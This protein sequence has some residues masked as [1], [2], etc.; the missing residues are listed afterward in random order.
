MNN[1][2][3]QV[4]SS[5]PLS[6]GGKVALALA[7]GWGRGSP[8]YM[9]A[10]LTAIL[11]K[12]GFKTYPFDIN[13]EM[14]HLSKEKDKL[15]WNWEES[16]F[17]QK[18]E[19]LDKYIRDN[20]ELIDSVIERVLSYGIEAVGFSIYSSTKLMSLELAKRIK[21]K[22]KSISVIFG[23]IECQRK[24]D[25]KS[26]LM[27]D[28]VDIL[29]FDEADEVFTELLQLLFNKNDL[30]ICKGIAYKKNGLIIDSGRR[31][32]LSNLDFLPF[33]DF[34]DFDFS[35]YENNNPSVLQI[36]TSRGCSEHCAY[37]STRD[38]SVKFRTMSGSRIF[39][40]I[41]HQAR[42]FKARAKDNKNI[43][44]FLLDLLVNADLKAL[45]EWT[46]KL[47][48]ER[49][50]D[51]YLA[52]IIWHGQIILRKGMSQQLL[53]NIRESG[54][55][56]LNY[57]VESGSSNVLKKMKKR[58]S[59]EE[60]EI[61][62]KEIYDSNIPSRGNFMFG[63]P[64]ETEDDFQ[65]T[66]NFISRTGRYMKEIY[67]SRTFC[68]L[69]RFSYL[70]EHRDEFGITVP[71]EGG[72]NLFWESQDG[73]N[74]YLVRLKRY[75][76]FCKL[77][78]SLPH[79]PLLTG[80]K[81]LKRDNYFNLGEYYRFI[82]DYHKAIENYEK[83]LNSGGSGTSVFN[84]INLC[85]QNLDTKTDNLN[86]E[87]QYSRAKNSSR[88]K[89]ISLNNKEFEEKKIQLKSTPPHIY[90]QIDGPCN[91]NCIFCSRPD[92]YDYFKFDIFHKEL[93]GK[94]YPL[95][96]NAE[97][98]YLTGAGEFLLLEEA[99][100][101]L[102]YFNEEFPDVD[103]MFATNGSIVTPEITREITKSNYQIHVSLHASNAQLHK[104][105][106]YSDNF[107]K[108]IENVKF[109]QD[110]YR[111]YN[112][113]RVYLMFLVTIENIEDL[114]DF[115]ILA[116]KL[117]V[118][119]VYCDFVSIYKIEQKY[120]SVFF[121][122]ESANSIF[123]RSMEL[124][125]QLNITLNLPWKFNQD[126][127]PEVKCTQPWTQVM[128]NSKGDVLPCCLFGDFGENLFNKNFV[129]I[130]NG[131]KYR[132]LRESL[133]GNKDVFCKSCLRKKPSSINEFSAHIISRGLSEDHFEQLLQL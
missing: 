129:E 76:I 48:K 28:C 25:W 121:K 38:C 51:R 49:K 108:I 35:R 23:G 36:A 97:K 70:D 89:N 18:K 116:S 119:D 101:I 27:Q 122:K 8:P 52:D 67:P 128:I 117:G 75:E 32:P 11:R 109:L 68:A 125:K 126:H 57:G 24:F 65:E 96:S 83:Y 91:Q 63:F 54:C 66:L 50:V 20:N 45:E 78:D 62:I 14:Y 72:D 30:S 103:K 44:I 40:E 19:S 22:R 7:P 100:K 3:Y 102:Q 39:E 80:V 4:S 127:Y 111:R 93:E 74:N 2:P 64:T 15:L 87:A 37:C 113:P 98:I 34:S 16:C 21:A 12:E 31:S 112:N 58:L 133:I 77:V 90:F 107:D 123:D 43:L 17:W 10:L 114:P 86:K 73:N 95:F 84:L 82:K 79:K 88:N 26:L 29:V 33:A 120:L 53:N 9:M 81:D 130:W 47:A 106:T 110:L 115:I 118:K 71:Y 42:A 105:L 41:K 13:N 60:M 132:L 85:N 131:E 92:K 1:C 46:G 55:I 56:L 59:P 124:A 69:E 104:K 61:V 5:K 94:V 99:G 6:S